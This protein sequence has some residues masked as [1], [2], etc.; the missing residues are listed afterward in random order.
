V[1]SQLI[2]L[3]DKFDSCVARAESLTKRLNQK[4][5]RNICVGCETDLRDEDRL[6]YHSKLA[7][8]CDCCFES[9]TRMK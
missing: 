2:S 1:T 8:Y 4:L 5:Q 9:V 3:L 7:T 6:I